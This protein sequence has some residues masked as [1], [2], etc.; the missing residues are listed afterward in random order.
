MLAV[1]QRALVLAALALALMIAGPGAV[2][3]LL[4]IGGV[5]LH[6]AFGWSLAQTAQR[7][8]GTVQRQR[9]PRGADCGC[10]SG[11]QAT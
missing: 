4:F 2:L 8:G 11:R 10:D 9:V 7:G 3:L 5:A 6:W 1:R